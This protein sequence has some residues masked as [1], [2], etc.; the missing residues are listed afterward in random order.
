MIYVITAVTYLP[1]VLAVGA[2]AIV[3]LLASGLLP[4]LIVIALRWIVTGIWQFGP[5]GA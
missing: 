1:D 2:A 5:R 4:W 3:V